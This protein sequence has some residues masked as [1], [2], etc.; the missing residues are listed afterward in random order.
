MRRY[1]AAA[2]LAVAAFTS[3]GC[4]NAAGRPPAPKPA[5]MTVDPGRMPPRV[6]PPPIATPR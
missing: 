4:L 5:P 1:I 2:A 3:A 6:P